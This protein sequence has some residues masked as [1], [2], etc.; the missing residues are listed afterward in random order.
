MWVW[1][2]MNSNY[3]KYK[4]ETVYI[5]SD[6]ISQK[7][8]RKEKYT[9]HNAGFCFKA[10]MLRMHVH[11]RI[12]NLPL[13][14]MWTGT[15]WMFQ[16]ILAY[17]VNSCF[18]VLVIT[19]WLIIFNKVW[20]R[21]VIDLRCHSPGLLNTKSIICLLSMNYPTMKQLNAF[22]GQPSSRFICH[23]RLLFT[24]HEQFAKEWI[25]SA[26]HV[27]WR[28]FVGGTYLHHLA[29]EERTA[30]IILN[31]QYFILWHTAVQCWLG[32]AFWTRHW[33]TTNS[34]MG[35]GAKVNKI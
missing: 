31:Q 30:E 2:G 18:R 5:V 22:T 35:V 24:A 33:W 1:L 28:N 10:W 32:I 20:E 8:R 34:D 12:E 16:H 9:E 25:T 6:L 4:L 27:C 14:E 15:S 19:T 23:P 13:P 26:Q 29:T 11:N 17:T 7:L 3:W 21:S